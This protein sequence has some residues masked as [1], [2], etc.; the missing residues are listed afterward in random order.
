M[1]SYSVLA[2]KVE[3]NGEINR[4]THA[5]S[6]HNNCLILT[7][8]PIKKI[9]YSYSFL[10]ISKKYHCRHEQNGFLC[11]R[12]VLYLFMALSIVIEYELKLQWGSIL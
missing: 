7:A 12:E 8:I 6:V 1:K 3:K 9:S 4:Q 10:G 11:N 2:V 5:H